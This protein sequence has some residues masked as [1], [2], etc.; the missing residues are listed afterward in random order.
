MGD[1][2]NPVGE[3]SQVADAQQSATLITEGTQAPAGDAVSDDQQAPVSGQPEGDGSNAVAE[4]VPESYAEFTAPEGKSFNS[5]FVEKFS[6]VAKG[7]NLSQESAQTLLSSMSPVIEQQIAENVAAVRNQWADEMRSDKEIGGD[8]LGETISIAKLAV[9][10]YCSPLLKEMLKPLDPENNPRG[11]GLGDNPEI[12]R[13]FYRVGM[14][15]KQDT[16]VTSGDGISASGGFARHASD[17]LYDKTSSS[18]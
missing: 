7:L 17:V 14:Q 5:E 3:T 8:R 18:K 2:L 16:V 11:T 1:P 4:G 10:A 12:V 13:L 9:D 15:L 6:S